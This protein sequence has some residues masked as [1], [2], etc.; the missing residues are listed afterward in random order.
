M[1]KLWR[2]EASVRRFQPLADLDAARLRSELAAIRH[3]DL[4]EGRGDRFQ[5]IVLVDGRP[6]GWITLVVHNW[7]H[8]LAE[9]GYALATPYQKQG[10]MEEALH[11]LLDEI[12]RRTGIERLEARCAVDNAASIRVLEK[13]GFLREGV[14][15]SYFRL[16]G[17]RVD[18]VLYAVLRD[19]HIA[20]VAKPESD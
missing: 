12:F 1:L 16:D 15:R 18:N 6:A 2:R 9:W 11:Q 10:L 8:G 17:R 5:W 13:L 4:Y 20:S 19:D 3:R 7:E 14:L